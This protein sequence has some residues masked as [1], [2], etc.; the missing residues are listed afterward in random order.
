V[1]YVG[2]S[3]N[4]LALIPAR[5]CSKGIPKKNTKLLA[6]KP[7]I[8]YTIEAALQS[9]CRPRVVVSTD[10]DEIA[11]VARAAGAEVPFL[12][13][14]ELAHD[15]TPTFPVVQHAL[16][17]LEQHEAY[18]P[19]LVVLLQPTSPLRR[20]EH[21]DQALELILSSGADSVVSLC[22]TEHSPYWMKKVDT[23]GHVS[24]FID[25]K[26]EYARR[27]DLPEVYRLN[28]AM[29]VTRSEVIIRENR[30]LGY[31]TRAY[32]M[33]QGDSIDIDTELDFKLAELLIKERWYN[34]K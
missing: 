32:I 7:L 24:P 9:Q 34:R 29:F 18:Q 20:A 2:D 31:D 8:S 28:G 12:R 1:I 27:Q 13:P 16:Q 10:D 21:I 22:E 23:K 11:R 4:I 15:E 3:F 17:W 26:E 30:L 19:E 5:G 14:A 6:G 25:M 33:D